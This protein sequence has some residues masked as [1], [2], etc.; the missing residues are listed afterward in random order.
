M[1]I[2]GQNFFYFL[3]GLLRKGTIQEK[4]LWLMTLGIAILILTP[5]VRVIM[6]VAYF[7]GRKDIKY[8]LITFFVFILLTISL[9]F[10]Y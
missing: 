5:Y 10:H 9:L 2:R 4:G 3:L 8:S 7:I 1:F 6:S